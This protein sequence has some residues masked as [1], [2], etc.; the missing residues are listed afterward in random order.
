[1]TTPSTATASA[2][3]SLQMTARIAA[4][5]NHLQRR[6]RAAQY[7]KSKGPTAT[8]SGWKNSHV[9]HWYVGLRSSVAA[10][11]TPAHFDRNRS[12]PSRKIATAPLACARTCT[13]SRKIGPAPNQ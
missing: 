7:A 10:S 2:T 5:V 6:L 3:S 8:A 4:T 13:T 9:S 11:A 1:M 12:R